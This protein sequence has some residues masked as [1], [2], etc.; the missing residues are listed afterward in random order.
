MFSK[1]DLLRLAKV[2]GSN[3]ISVFL[4]T[5][6]KSDGESVKR[7]QLAFKNQVNAICEYLSRRG[8]S[9]GDINELVM[10]LSAR[11]DDQDFWNNQSSGLAIFLGTGFF[12]EYRLPISFKPAFCVSTGFLVWPLMR[13]LQ[14]NG[15]FYLLSLGKGKIKLYEASRY[16]IKRMQIREFDEIRMEAVV[17]ADFVQKNL[18]YRSP[19]GQQS[20]AIYHSH[21]EGRED[22]GVEMKKF[23]RAVSKIVDLH[24]KNHDSPLM[25]AGLDHHV[26]LFKN[27]YHPP[28][29]MAGYLPVNPE[30]KEL[31]WLH[32]QAW[33]YVKDIYK[34]KKLAGLAKFN[35]TMNTGKTEL[36]IERIL[37]AA[38]QGKIDTIFIR[39]GLEIWGIYNPVKNTVRVDDH[40]TSSNVSL[41]NLLTLR[42]I[43]KGGDVFILDEDE[44]PDGFLDMYALFRYG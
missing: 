1:H 31:S 38:F 20:Q 25:L 22:Q 4:P 10:P 37:P 3:L 23:F 9:P 7:D 14:D 36:E 39:N 16:E 33:S 29:L 30:S 28:N 6:S 17:G 43:E 26:S 32:T 19:P 13:L 2:R 27:V 44:L 5:T 18:Q 21:G 12:E 42:V 40:Q 11:L 34:K 35:R 15:S 24:I 41:I 8:L